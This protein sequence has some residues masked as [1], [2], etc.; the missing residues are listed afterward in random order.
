MALSLLLPLLPLLVP[1]LSLQVTE[2]QG[3]AFQSPYVNQIVS[4]SGTVT[5]KVSCFVFKNQYMFTFNI[6]VQGKSGF[7]VTGPPSEDIRIS[8]GVMVYSTAASVLNAVA[9]GDSVALSAEVAGQ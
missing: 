2:I 6:L 1:V 8:N 5:A 3:S 9:V 4:V 7:W